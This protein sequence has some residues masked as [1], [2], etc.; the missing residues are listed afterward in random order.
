MFTKPVQCCFNDLLNCPWQTYVVAIRPQN[1]EQ[2]S[3]L[4]QF[5]PYD[6]SGGIDCTELKCAVV[7]DT[8]TF[9]STEECFE[10]SIEECV[11]DCVEEY[12]ST[13]NCVVGLRTR[14]HFMKNQLPA[15]MLNSYCDGTYFIATTTRII[16][17]RGAGS[18]ELTRG[19]LSLRLSYIEILYFENLIAQSIQWCNMTNVR[20]RDWA[21]FGKIFLLS[22]IQ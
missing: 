9:P 20:R 21:K 18:E 3:L 2:H 5:W 7:Q 1:I 6:E 10:E 17:Y 12:L 14:N 13:R 19:V 8:V 4:L 11:E 15:T 22:F 16:N